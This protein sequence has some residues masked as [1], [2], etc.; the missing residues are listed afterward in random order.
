MLIFGIVL[1]ISVP[2]YIF[3]DIEADGGTTAKEY[4]LYLGPY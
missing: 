1:S 2:L 4:F 3:L